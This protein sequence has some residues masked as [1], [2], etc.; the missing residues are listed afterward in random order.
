MQMTQ[1]RVYQLL[2]LGVKESFKIEL[3]NASHFDDEMSS[4]SL[5][6][7]CVLTRQNMKALC[8]TQDARFI[9][10]GL[11]APPFEKMPSLQPKALV[12][13]LCN[14]AQGHDQASALQWR[15]YL[16]NKAPFS[17]EVIYGQGTEMLERI[18][19]AWSA[20]LQNWQLQVSADLLRPMA[21]ARYKAYC[22]KCSDPLCES[23]L[24]EMQQ[25]NPQCT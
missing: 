15:T 25:Q 7:Q 3:L 1:A 22:E 2:L 16:T 17:Y 9:L 24:F 20:A 23:R 18:R 5:L 4:V 13:L 11:S 21:S 8:P 12:L 19:Y 10:Q 6:D 14:K